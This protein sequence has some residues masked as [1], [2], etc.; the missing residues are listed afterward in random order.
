MRA[1]NFQLAFCQ[2]NHVVLHV[3]ASD[4]QVVTVGKYKWHAFQDLVHEALEGL[5]GPAEPER[6]PE[7]LECT[8]GR[9]D[10]GLEHVGL[11]DFD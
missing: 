6:H 2:V 11:V 8:K 4:Q 1:Q 9:A 10:C 5:A 3:V 7:K